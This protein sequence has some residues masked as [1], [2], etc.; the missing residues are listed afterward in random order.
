MVSLMLYVHALYILI[1]SMISSL[2]VSVKSSFHIEDV[3]VVLAKDTLRNKNVISKMSSVIQKFTPPIYAINYYT[4]TILLE[5]F[6]NYVFKPSSTL[7][8]RYY[9]NPD[10]NVHVDI[11]EYSQNKVLLIFFLGLGGTTKNASYLK[12]WF[13]QCYKKGYSMAI[14]N[15]ATNKIPTHADIKDMQICIEW[16]AAKYPDYKR[17]AIGYSAGGNHLIRTLGFL[18]LDSNYIN[19]AITVSTNHYLPDTAKFLIAT[20]FM[21]RITG[22]SQNYILNKNTKNSFIDLDKLTDLDTIV[23][24]FH[25]YQNVMQ[26]YEA[27]S[28]DND[29]KHIKIPVLTVFSKDDGLCSGMY[30]RMQIITKENENVMAIVTNIGG[31]VA[32]LQKDDINQPWIIDVVNKYIESILESK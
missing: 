2:I 16:L 15:R 18:E 25:R 7:L 23:A 1:T 6:Y 12:P 21:N 29:L 11:A 5:I 28:S 17:I 22:I 27:F 3:P 31:H 20:P 24:T 13:K 4:Q 14:I 19:A 10:S 9:V 30:E 32:W 26:Y 8:E